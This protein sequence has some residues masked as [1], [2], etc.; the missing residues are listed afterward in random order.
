MEGSR[1]VWGL[2]QSSSQV[3]IALRKAYSPHD[4][5][6]SRG[7]LLASCYDALKCSELWDR[8]AMYATGEL[9]KDRKLVSHYGA[10]PAAGQDIDRRGR[11]SN[12]TDPGNKMYSKIYDLLVH[13]GNHLM[14]LTPRSL[15]ST[16]R[17]PRGTS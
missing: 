17:K 8:M 4:R 6:A 15:S 12:Y 5:P 10:L 11:W 2:L 1:Q 7:E 9:A 14:N 16:A 13:T 3:P